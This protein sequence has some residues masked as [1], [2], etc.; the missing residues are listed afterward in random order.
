MVNRHPNTW[1][2]TYQYRLSVNQKCSIIVVGMIHATS[3]WWRHQMET[4]SAL[5]A[6]C[7]G[8][9]PV[10]G[11]FPAQRPVTRGFD[12][13]FDMRPNK[14]FSKQWRGWWFEMPSRPLWRL[15]NDVL[16][17]VT[18]GLTIYT[19]VAVKLAIKLMGNSLAVYGI[20]LIYGDISSTVSLHL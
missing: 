15:C 2:K 4:F 3:L 8:N 9:S 5:L 13:F 14:R 11:E 16:D 6:I 17:L 1:S 20:N 18:T 12:V 7:A 10:T 19:R